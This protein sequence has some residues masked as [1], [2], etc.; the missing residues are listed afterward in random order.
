[1]NGSSPISVVI[2]C[3]NDGPFLTDC[4]E[5]VFAQTLK[6]T[7]ILIVNDGSTDRKT[8]KFLENIHL[9]GVR[10]ID[11]ENLGL[12]G[13]R[14]TGIRNAKGKYIYFLDADNILLP[15]CLAELFPL[16][17]RQEEAIA[18]Y[19]KIRFS[20]GPMDGL[21]WGE[22]YNPYL[23]LVNNLWDAGILLRRDAV[24]QYDLFYDETMRHGYED[25][26]FN[27]R[28][29]ATG[30]PILFCPRPLYIY[31]VRKKSLLKTSHRLHQQIVSYIFNKQRT[32]YAAEN[33]LTLKRQF[34]PA[35]FVQCKIEEE[36]ALRAWLQEQ[37]FRDWTLCT[38]SS[39]QLVENARYCLAYSELSA[40]QRLPPEALE[41][42]LIALESDLKL[43]HCVIAVRNHCLP[44]FAAASVSANSSGSHQ[45]VAFLTRIPLRKNGSNIS[46]ILQ[47]CYGLIE[48]L[49][50]M[51]RS[52]AGWSSDLL[53]LGDI[54]GLNWK[55][56]ATVRKRVSSFS[57][58][59][60]GPTL[61]SKCLQ[62]YD[63]IYYS[64]LL[65]HKSFALR[66]TIRTHLGEQIERRIS[67]GFY[68]L[69][70][71]R[72]PTE[73]STPL[74][75]IKRSSPNDTSPLFINSG[76]GKKINVLIATSWLTEGGVEQHIFDL[77]RLLD[78]SRF[79]IFIVTTRSS[80]HPWD[81]VA[82]Q[83]G[84]SVYHLGDFL[85]PNSI[86][87][88]LT[89]LIVNHQIDCLHI[90]QSRETYMALKTLARFT[91]WL[92]IS[93]RIELLEPGG[94]YPLISAKTGRN[95]I[96]R[97]TVS[98]KNLARQMHETY[99]I[100]EELIQTIYAGTDTGRTESVLTHKSWLLHKMCNLN[101]DTPIVTFVGRMTHQKRP[102]IFLR[103]VAKLLE[104]QPDCPAHFAM[105]GDGEMRKQVETVVS[106]YQLQN[107]VHLLGA[108]PNAME[109]IADATLLMM[110]SA[111]EGLALVSYEAMALGVPQIFAN[112]NGQAELITPETGILI[113]NGPGEV[114]RYAKACL[115]LLSDPDRRARMAAAGKERIRHFTAENAV[116]QYE[117]IFD[118]LAELSRKR[119]SEIPHLRPPH[120]NPLHALT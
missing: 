14:N 109:L 20:G 101:S 102:D 39:A 113:D 96:H 73:E 97:Q 40:L 89:H 26:E 118:E 79:R 75:T 92:S 25:W 54:E 21:E 111:Y 107:H 33:L 110:P 59:L 48:F 10:V 120:I 22:P 108:H 77:C 6:P 112:V 47:N 4:L 34:A 55:D 37:T 2:P 69:F 68:G 1:M 70:L 50:Q 91:P 57:K 62:A 41:C 99:K 52:R 31:R 58:K 93:D 66:E 95:F 36:A 90:V 24:R 7:E 46:D 16:L 60:L 29:A 18:A 83:T 72:P 30:K 32:A 19:S 94:G 64:V 23:L 67:A 12:A 84:A 106:Q 63:T 28:L 119:A 100:P 76:P 43:P 9:P 86:P 61:H 3:F 45:P 53:G 44:L 81:H 65:S 5:S 82:R 27:I 115:E 51:P 104:L 74:E 8:I 78:S 117:E 56:I 105:V 42:A 88:A 87:Y 85:R 116:K 11:Q 71:A 17:E 35:L 13:A 38:T 80:S 15:E 114:T 49:D 103:S 98:H